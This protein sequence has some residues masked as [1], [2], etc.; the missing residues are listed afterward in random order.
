MA[1]NKNQQN[2]FR[3]SLIKAR[4]K[5]QDIK[6]A[7]LDKLL[8]EIILKDKITNDKVEELLHISDPTATRY[9][10][11]LEKEGKIRQVGKTGKHI[12][13]EPI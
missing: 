6:K 3:E 1:E 11:I 7:K 2:I 12:Y 8:Q 4:A 5:R 10:D 13:Y 9:L